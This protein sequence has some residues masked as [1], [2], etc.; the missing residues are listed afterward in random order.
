MKLIFCLQRNTKVFYKMIASLW[1]YVARHAEST[2]NNKLTTYLQ[3]FKESM[4][5]EVDFLPAD[6]Y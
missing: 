4:K 2:G 3:Y 5:N 6:K 1:V